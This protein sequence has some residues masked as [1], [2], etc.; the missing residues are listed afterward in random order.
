MNISLK[1]SYNIFSLDKVLMK[2]KIAKVVGLS[3]GAIGG[4]LTMLGGA[5]T[6]AT[7]GAALPVFIAG[8]SICLASGIGEGAAAISE[9]IIKSKQLKEAQEAIDADKEATSLLEQDISCVQ[10]NKKVLNMMTKD[11]ILSGGSTAYESMHLLH[12]VSG[13][14]G[15][16]ALKSGIQTTANVFGENVGKEVIDIM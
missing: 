8:T 5:L 14:A 10:S 11:V 4:G 2:T 12:L 13:K 7:A 3:G 1:E 6:I 9:K 16:T 15:E